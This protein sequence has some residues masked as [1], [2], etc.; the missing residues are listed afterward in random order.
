MAILDY[1]GTLTPIV[2]SPR[3]AALAPSVRKTLARLAASERVRLAILSGRALGDVRARVGLDGVVYG[4]CHGLEIQGAGLRFRHPRARASRIAAARRALAAGAASIP[5][6]RVEFKGLA[7]SLHYRQVAPSRRTAARALAARVAR[8]M[9]DLS[10]IAGHA[11]VDFVPRVGWNKGTA[12]RWIARRLGPARSRGRPIVL[13]AGDDV[14]DEAAFAA[15]RGRGVTVRVGGGK[16][17]A[18]YAVLGV[19]QMHMLLRRLAR[20]IG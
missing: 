20:L 12:A 9:P 7:V 11:V 17:R 18:E 2:A 3:A 14:T 16:S 13:Y 1:D 19:G 15:L 5:G 8:R 4:G 6:A 10:V